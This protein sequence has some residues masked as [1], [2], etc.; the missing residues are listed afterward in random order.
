MN[1]E[2]TQDRRKILG[3]AAA[4]AL[5]I[6]MVASAQ[7]PVVQPPQA[8]TGSSNL[9]NPVQV[10]YPNNQTRSANQ[11]TTVHMNGPIVQPALPLRAPSLSQSKRPVTIVRTP[12]VQPF[13]QPKP[14]TFWQRHPMVKGAAIGGGIGAG[15]GALTGLIT[16][17]GIVRGAA[18]GACTGAG[19]GV[20]R[21]SQVLKRHPIIRD[22]ATGGLSGLGLGWAGS[23]SR[24]ATLATTGIGSA[25]GLGA[26]LLGNSSKF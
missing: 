9:T 17:Q 23:H 13:T 5:A 12:D 25:I 19:V 22:V 2:N 21:T 20:I 3:L 14:Q 16:G 6:T 18:I 24:G 15:T 4:L 10:N 1:L 7:A 26:G 11:I 8:V